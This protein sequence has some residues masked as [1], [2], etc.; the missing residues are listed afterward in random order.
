AANEEESRA[1]PLTIQFD[2]GVHG[3]FR[4]EPLPHAAAP[5]DDIVAR[6]FAPLDFAHVN[7]ERDG[8]PLR[9]ARLERAVELFLLT[10]AADEK[11][12][13]AQRKH[14]TRPLGDDVDALTD[15]RGASVQLA[16]LE[17]ERIEEIVDDALSAT[18]LEES[19]RRL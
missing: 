15:G 4:I 12:G 2:D 6:R 10:R 9:V 18:P 1:Q 11:V 16:Q 8:N 7:P 3:P 19:A 14:E 17:H 5:D 13:E